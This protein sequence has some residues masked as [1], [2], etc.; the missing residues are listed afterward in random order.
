MSK[1]IVISSADRDAPSAW[2]AI[3]PRLASSARAVVLTGAGVSAES[4]LATFRAGGLWEGH[5]VKEV[6]TPQAFARNPEMVW[7][8]YNA[9]RA[10]LA[11]AAPNPAHA[12]LTDL[13]RALSPGLTLVTQNVDGLHQAA[14]STDVLELHGSLRRSRCSACDAAVHG[15]DPLPVLP[16]CAC[17]ALLRPDV[18]WFGEMLPD[19]VMERAAE[20]TV[21]ADVLLVVGT[22]AVVYPAAGLVDI[23]RA[24]GA[25]VIEVNPD[26]T[27]ASARADIIL[28]GT[29]GAMV[30]ELVRR[31]VRA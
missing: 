27:D 4:G 25:T 21:R 14:G 26:E 11:A 15:L 13:Q 10:A 7:R 12:A 16:R 29:A 17:G 8:F 9:R 30:P 22:S 2:A 5:D 20:D 6:A 19:G 18:V 3:T 31:W 24:G 23:A 1:P 28:R